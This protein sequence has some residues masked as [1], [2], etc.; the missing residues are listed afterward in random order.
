MIIILTRIIDDNKLYLNAKNI[1]AF[2]QYNGSYTDW[3]S[4]EKDYTEIRS[5]DNRIYEV[6]ETPEEI[7][8]LIN[9]L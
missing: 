5:L 2:S 9:N 6:K 4:P 1:I 3:L 7:I 8:N